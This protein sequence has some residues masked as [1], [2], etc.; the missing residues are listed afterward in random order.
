MVGNR[1][2][3]ALLWTLA[4]GGRG[5]IIC[6]A[7]LLGR[8]GVRRGECGGWLRAS[9][10]LQIVVAENVSRVIETTLAGIRIVEILVKL[11]R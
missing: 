10:S 5:L 9:E 2:G 6:L 11:Y 3:V 8:L 7:G 1:V 4:T